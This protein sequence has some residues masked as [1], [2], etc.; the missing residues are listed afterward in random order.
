MEA[1][2][3]QWKYG[4]RCS[5]CNRPIPL[6]PADPPDLPAIVFPDAMQH[7]DCTWCGQPNQFNAKDAQRY[8]AT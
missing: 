1:K 6:A 8:Q 4:I 5:S 7:L 3:G 2:A